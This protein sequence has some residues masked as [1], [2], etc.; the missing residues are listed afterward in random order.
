M[1]NYTIKIFIITI[2]LIFLLS[3]FLLH[4][5]NLS[6]TNHL[7]MYTVWSKSSNNFGLFKECCLLSSTFI[8]FLQNNLHQILQ[9]YV[10]ILFQILKT[11]LEC[12]WAHSAILVLCLEWSKKHPFMVF[13]ACEEKKVTSGKYGSYCIIT[14]LFLAQN[15]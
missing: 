11:F 6:Q 2:Q 4:C 7:Q 8:L 1:H 9:A 3:Q 12:T 14:M 5:F 15:I 13:S 10:D